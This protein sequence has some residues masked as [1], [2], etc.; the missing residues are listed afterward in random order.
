MPWGLTLATF[1]SLVCPE[2]LS[3]GRTRALGPSCC[4]L[5]W[6][7]VPQQPFLPTYH[8]RSQTR[9]KCSALRLPAASRS[10][11]VPAVWGQ[12]GHLCF[13]GNRRAFWAVFDGG[14]GGR[15]PCT[16]RCWPRT[17]GWRGLSEIADH[18]FL[19]SGLAVLPER[20][21]WS[22]TVRVWE[23]CPPPRRAPGDEQAEKVI[24]GISMT[25]RPTMG[26]SFLEPLWL[27]AC[28]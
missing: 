14:A 25:P 21:G 6:G 12:Q 23:V 22:E 24:R 3:L 17:L 26:P 9:G 19:P 11:P 18:G 2:E 28:Q 20:Q 7:D 4:C 5:W 27:E 1:C 10:W 13:W 16:S 8:P 15:G